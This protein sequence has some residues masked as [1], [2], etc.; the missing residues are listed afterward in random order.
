[1]NEN[2]FYVNAKS[3][4]V[5]FLMSNYDDFPVK[6]QNR[7]LNFFP[8]IA[9]YREEGVPYHPRILFT[10]GIDAVAKCLPAPKKIEMFVDKNENMFDSRLRAL[11]PFCKTEWYIYVETVPG[12]TSYGLVRNISSIKDKALEDIIFSDQATSEKIAAK[13][14]VIYV[15]ANTRWTVTM[16]S[17]YG[18]TLNTNFALDIMG[19]SDM[20]SQVAALV[21]ASFSKLK[22]TARKMDELK[23]MF[24]NVFK[25]VLRDIGGTIC[26]VVDKDYVCDEFLS[27]GIWLTEPVSLSKLFLQTTNY[28]EQKL[29]ATANLFLSMLHK[30][31]I[32]VI[33]N[34]GDIRAF[35]VFVETNLRELSNIIGG[36]RK[37]AAYTVIQSKRRD[38]MGVYFQSY[39]GEIFYADV[40]R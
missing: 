12:R 40:K 38:I 28:N 8:L 1:M 30:D 24:R 13:A 36:A 9:N 21:D 18:N 7:F 27:D 31:G 20:D 34:T 10:N 2:V 14:S 35:N 22:T 39:D 15:Y 16:Q 11:I 33:D 37:R 25:N 17:F 23:T 32:T 19:Y 5:E 26:V 6:L 29:T 4:I 3:K